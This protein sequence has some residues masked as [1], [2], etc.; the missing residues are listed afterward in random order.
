MFT[1]IVLASLASYSFTGAVPLHFVG[2]LVEK[3]ITL[4]LAPVERRVS[5]A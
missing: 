1:G 4:E 3:T 5:S 2:T